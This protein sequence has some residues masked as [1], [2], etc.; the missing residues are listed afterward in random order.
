M[1][2]VLPTK[3]IDVSARKSIVQLDGKFVKKAL[4]NWR[5]GIAIEWTDDKTKAQQYSAI[6][7][8]WL[9][10]QLTGALVIVT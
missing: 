2:R 9:S 4:Y 1:L 5:T 8:N 10:D 6:E 7:A 3:I